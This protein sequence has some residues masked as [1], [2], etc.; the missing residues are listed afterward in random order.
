MSAMSR[1]QHIA[2]LTTGLVVVP[3]PQ[4][5][6]CSV[7]KTGVAPGFTNCRL[8]RS[9]LHIDVVPISMSLHNGLLHDRLRNYKDGRSAVQ[10][11]EFTL[12]LAALV[13]AFL[14]RHAGCLGDFDFV[15]TVPSSRPSA[16][17]LVGYRDAPRSIVNYV[18]RLRNAGANPLS[19]DPQS[20]N[21]VVHPSVVGSRVL[22]MDD[23]FTTG[24]AV[25]SAHAALAKAD[26]D[27]V[28]PLVVGRHVQPG[29]H[30]K[31]KTGLMACL[32]SYEWSLD[33]CTR[34]RPMICDPPLR[35]EPPLNLFDN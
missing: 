6:I 22:L 2:R 25:F 5:G 9:N 21:V 30:D 12:D 17:E 4:A 34:C 11:N 15:A 27:V 32:R 13:S 28:G 35:N 7:C 8:C 29:Y 19:R 33:E 18:S 24:T 16:R 26:V 3:G 1:T 20:G 14:E 10:R 31:H 23:T